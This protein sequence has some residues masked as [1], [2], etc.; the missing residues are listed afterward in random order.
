MQNIVFIEVQKRIKPLCPI[1]HFHNL[2]ALRLGLR[3]VQIHRYN[4]IQ[5]REFLLREIVFCN[6]DIAFEYLAVRS[7]FPGGQ[8]HMRLR[9]ISTL[10]YQLCSRM[11]RDGIMQLVLYC[12]VKSLRNLSILI[13]VRTQGVYIRNLEIE[14]PFGRTNFPYFF[15]K[16]IKIILTKAR[17]VLQPFGIEHKTF[18]HIVL[19]CIRSPYTEA[20]CPL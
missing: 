10:Y 1:R 5:C 13:I 15:K 11:P 20:R 12:L 17:P 7:I 16:F 18:D 4:A 6:I 8:P 2:L 19:Q 9:G 3:I 14:S